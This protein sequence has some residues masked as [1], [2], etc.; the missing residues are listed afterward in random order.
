M[1]M[2][3]IKPTDRI[4]LDL[5]MH[6]IDF[7]EQKINSLRQ[8]VANKYNIPL[9]NVEINFV[10]INVDENGD[11]VALTNDIIKNIQDP[12]FQQKLFGEWL[13]IR[14]IDDVNLDEINA[15]DNSINAHIDFDAYSKFKQYKFKY[16]KWKNYLSYGTEN[17]FDFTKLHGLVLLN[18]V[19][20]NQCGKTTLAIDLLR[21]AL[22]GKAEKSPTLDSVFNI[23]LPEETEVVVEAGLEI[24]GNDYIIRRT[25]TRPSLKKRT[26]RSKAKQKIEYFKIFNGNYE[27]IENCEGESSTQTNNIIGETVGSV[28]DYNLV[29]SATAY[30]LSDLLRMGQSDKGKLFSRWLGLLTIEEKE[31]IAK[32]I[33]K[34]NIQPS[35][36]SN[37]YNKQNLQ[38]EVANMRAVI[39][40]DE[41]K[42]ADAQK[43]LE[44]TRNRLEKFELEKTGILNQKK[45]IKEELC[46]KDVTTIENNLEMYNDSLTN[47]RAQMAQFKD[48]Y[49]LIKDATYDIDKHNQLNSELQQYISKTGELKANISQKRDEIK[50]VQKLIDDKICPVCQQPIDVANKTKQIDE[51]NTAINSLIKDGVETKS[52]IDKTKLEIDKCN[53]DRQKVEQLEKLKLKMTALK[54]Q[55]D[56]VKLQISNLKQVLEDIEK[57]KEN[58]RLNNEIDNKVRLVDENIKTENTIKEAKIKDITNFNLESNMLSLE[59]TKR[60]KVI[61]KLQEEEILIRNWNIYLQLVGKNGVVKIVLKRAL[62]VINNEIERLISGLCDFKVDLNISDDGKVNIDMIRDGQRMDLGVCASGW[63]KT[64][65]SLALRCSLSNIATLPRSQFVVFDEI[66]SGV[67]AE[68]MENV[69]ELYRRVMNSYDFILHICHD[70]SLLDYHNQ[71][72]TICKKDNVSVVE[73]ANKQ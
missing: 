55:I 11:K 24:E 4:V 71:F 6:Q 34:N 56:N 69:M 66:L 47:K 45:E 19:P 43:Q 70:N 16:V 28:E 13:K 46:K 25:V 2:Q 63:E 9:K 50:R 20:E 38:D 22:F 36:L 30:T 14:E 68:N 58:I 15:I 40:D 61:E 41:K 8:E 72:I 27:L 10:P 3:N 26:A 18:G 31:K 60:E 39:Q 33:Y 49:A 17:Y 52:L 62:P 29:M 42:K 37:Q 1:M 73:F 65:A 67:S 12:Q 7:N 64:I 51:I 59:I 54:V 53:E 48:E 32:D 21:F 57:N 35:L 23:Y 5:E 44:E